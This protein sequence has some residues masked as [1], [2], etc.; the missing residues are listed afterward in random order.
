MCYKTH[1]LK[2]TRSCG[3]T[4]GCY[5]IM[6][7][8]EITIDGVPAVVYGEKSDKVFI[9][10][11][12]LCGNKYEAEEFAKAAQYGGYQVL[13]VDLPEHGG[14]TDGK[15]LLPWEVV[16]E[17]LATIGFAMKEW[18]EL[19]VRA[20]SI[21]AYFSLLAFSGRKIKKCLLVS[22]LIDMAGM[23]K[24]MMGA[25]GVSEEELEEKGEIRTD[26]GQTL[27]WKYL[28]FAREN[29]ISVVG[30]DVYILCARNDEVVPHRTVETFVERYACKLNVYEDGEHFF[31]TKDQVAYMRK[32]ENESLYGIDLDEIH[33][34]EAGKKRICR[35]L[36]IDEDPV[37]YCKKIIASE[38][39]KRE[40]KGKNV[41]FTLDNEV[42][43][44]NASAKSII[45]AH[46]FV[47]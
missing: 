9:C 4:L 32:W 35:N 2:R 33:T 42:I 10:V 1:V 6:K 43:T 19:N 45:T 11:H 26:F 3:K 21:G 8:N 29:P 46:K 20:V 47:K 36:G 31:H 7:T 17:L 12:G 16:P 37:G 25:A 41:Y 14:R 22:P 39:C 23:I 18:K 30:S 5:G 24:G 13:S 15:K 38:N 34:T 40:R 28:R 44:L 27:S